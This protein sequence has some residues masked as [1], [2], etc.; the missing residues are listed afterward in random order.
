M[1]EGSSFPPSSPTLASICH[2]DDNIPMCVKWCLI[3]VS[4]CISLMA[5]DVEYFFMCLLTI[6]ISSLEKCIFI[7][8]AYLQLAY[9]SFYH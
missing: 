9:L 1:S 7:S 5:N 4:I 2:F 8:F 6:F 3:G